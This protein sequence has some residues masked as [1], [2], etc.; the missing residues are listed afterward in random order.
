MGAHLRRQGWSG[1]LNAAVRLAGVL[2]QY[3]Y[4]DREQLTSCPGRAFPGEGEELQSRPLGR[5]GEG[6]R[7]AVRLNHGI[8]R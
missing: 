2:D 8:W 4:M 7:A 3:G 6:R 1:H 5:T